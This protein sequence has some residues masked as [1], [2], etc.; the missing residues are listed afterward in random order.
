MSR[1]LD[2]LP[3]GG[4]TDARWFATTATPKPADEVAVHRVD[5]FATDADAHAAFESAVNQIKACWT[6]TNARLQRVS[7]G[8]R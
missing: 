7:S 4:T 6:S 2:K 5:E 3:V 1:C 8:R